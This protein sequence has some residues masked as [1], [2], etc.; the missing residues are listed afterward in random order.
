MWYQ[1]VKE[2]IV[3]NTNV[4]WSVMQLSF[5]TVPANLRDFLTNAS[6][7]LLARIKNDGLMIPRY[8]ELT[9]DEFAWQV[10]ED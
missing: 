2:D 7:K 6:G 3:K 5:V 4:K 8:E 9:P 1:D 10:C